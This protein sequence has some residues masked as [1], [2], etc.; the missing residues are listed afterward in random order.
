MQTLYFCPAVSSVFYLPFFSSPNLIGRRLNVYIY[1][2]RIYLNCLQLKFLDTAIERS[3]PSYCGWTQQWRRNVQVTVTYDC[4]SIGVALGHKIFV[5]VA[6]DFRQ[7]GQ[8]W[9]LYIRLYIGILAVMPHCVVRIEQSTGCVS[10]CPNDNLLWSRH[11][12]L[13]FIL[14][15]YG[16]S[17]MVKVIGQSSTSR[18]K[19]T[20]GN[21][22]GYACSLPTDTMVWS[23]QS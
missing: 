23:V 4:Q 15:L 21:I 5:A 8:M 2:L 12:A 9:P 20:G 16:S 10:V 6:G 14:T 3:L 11:L 22:F 18:K 19:F 7:L 13:W 1:S 17:S